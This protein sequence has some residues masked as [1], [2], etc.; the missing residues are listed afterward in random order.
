MFE[1]FCCFVG[2][3]QLFGRSAYKPHAVALIRICMIL[4][5]ECTASTSLVAIYPETPT[6]AFIEVCEMIFLRYATSIP[7]ILK[8]C[9]ISLLLVRSNP[10]DIYLDILAKQVSI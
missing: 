10:I 8:Q 1:I 9:C 7:L 2:P 3:H 4:F 5:S 6:V